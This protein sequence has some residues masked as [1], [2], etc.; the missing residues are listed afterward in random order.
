MTDTIE[1]GSGALTPVDNRHQTDSE[2]ACQSD[3]HLLN[4][5]EAFLLSRRVGNCTARTLGF[6]RENLVRFAQ[7]GAATLRCDQLV[8]QRYL[9]RLR[10][11]MQAI[12]AHT[13][14]R[15][16]K[17]FFGWC[18]ET[19]LLRES[20]MHVITMKLPKTLPRVPE[21]DAVR[22]LLA[23]C[24]NTFEGRRNKALIGLLAD[25]GLHISEALRLRIED[26]RF[27]ERTVIVRGG[28]GQK[29]GVGFFGAE[30]AA[31]LRSWLQIR[32][33]AN[34]EDYLFTDKQGRPL[35]RSTAC[36]LLHRLSVRAGLPQKVGPHALRH[37]AA[38]NIL[39]Q[40]GDLELV[41]QVLRHE[42]LTMAL[43]YAQ[44]TKMD[45]SRKFR[46]ASPLTTCG[47]GARTA[48]WARRRLRR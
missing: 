13:H 20:P 1:T 3:A 33:D 39:K 22:K 7:F 23:A 25:S 4:A 47:R 26:V 24:P 31:L 10:D 21:D 45:V 43:K 42:S 38:T 29:D 32:Q 8:V 2:P 35:S 11:H 17:V 15:A 12:T 5:I 19:R 34:P 36:H 18:V 30:T 9:T 41:R 14:F 6:Y 44:I 27:G 46:R 40:T 37:Y 16:L 28:K 48:L